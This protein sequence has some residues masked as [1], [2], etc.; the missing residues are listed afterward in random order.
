MT[1]SKNY[2]TQ[3]PG[4]NES[5][6]SITP[7][8]QSSKSSPTKKSEKSIKNKQKDQSSCSKKQNT[9]SQPEPSEMSS[10]NKTNLFSNDSSDSSRIILSPIKR[11]KSHIPQNS[12]YK[13][14]RKPQRKASPPSLPHRSEYSSQRC[15]LKRYRPAF[16]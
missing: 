15:A 2:N 9:Y 10:N 11:K 12:R 13:S 6:G 14:N 3:Q 16:L 8:A 4:A 5:T 1:F 7:K